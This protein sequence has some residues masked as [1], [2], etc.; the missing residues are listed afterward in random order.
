MHK[1]KKYQV[2]WEAFQ[3]IIQGQQSFSNIVNW[4][5]NQANIDPSTSISN[6]TNLFNKLL[7]QGYTSKPLL[8][9][10]DYVSKISQKGSSTGTVAGKGGNGLNMKNAS[11]LLDAASAFLPAA[12]NNEL[13]NTI[14]QGYDSAANMAMAIPGVGAAIGGAM[15]LTSAL[16]K[17][18]SSLTGGA[19][20]INDAS[21]KGDEILSSNLF[22]LSPLGL[23]NSLTKTKIAGS[24]T[25][26]ASTINKGYSPTDGLEKTEIGGVTNFM[27]RLVGGKKK[28]LVKT[29]QNQ[30]NK[31]D[32][33]NMLKSSSIFQDNQNQLAAQNSY[34]DITTK[35][36]NQLLGGNRTNILSAKKG[37]KINPKKLSNIKNKALYE[38]SK[39][40]EGGQVNVIPEGALHARKNN[41][42]GELKDNV[43]HKG[44]P[45]ITY[46]E[47]GGIVQHAEIENSEI[48]F[49]KEVSVKLE[50]MFE[51]HKKADDKE[52]KEIEL[53]CGK[54][55]TEEILENTEDNV[56]LIE[57]IS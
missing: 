21:N 53:E 54:Y 7:A 42:E 1:I 49:S 13:S 20:T 5:P 52:K 2:P 15:K 36:N 48:I 37:A 3:G 26:L 39:F 57:T 8:Q 50:E 6:T 34:G 12:N 9:P 35:N 16:N 24:D 27:S 28:S 33:S 43:T 11:G 25:Q 23:T 10:K 18:L 32:T 31:I 29:R 22:A 47:D 14:N 19:T 51:K 40:K 30:V 45:V 55:L 38:V 44:I 4:N 41:Y 17:G 56:G 46:N